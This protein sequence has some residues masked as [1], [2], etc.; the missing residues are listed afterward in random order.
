MESND[1][2]KNRV[3]N[4]D[5]WIQLPKEREHVIYLWEGNNSRCSVSTQENI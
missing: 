4:M 1:A 2:E 5:G 3:G